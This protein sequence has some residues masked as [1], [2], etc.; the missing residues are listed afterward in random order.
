[1]QGVEARL[2]GDQP[3]DRSRSRLPSLRGSLLDRRGNALAASEDTATIFA[4]PPE[5]SKPALAAEKLAPILG[6][7]ESKVLGA[8]TAETTYSVLA[9]Q[10][11]LPTA[12]RIE[13]LELQGIGQD[14]DSRRIYPQG[15]LAAQVIGA[16]GTEN[17]GLTGLEEGE[18]SVLRG[19]D[20]ER[21]IVTDATG[22]PIRLE[23]AQ[24][25]EDGEDI[26]LTLDPGDRAE[27]RGSAGRSR[28]NL[29]AEGR[30]RDRD[31]PAQLAGPGD[32]QLAAGRSQRPLQRQPRRPA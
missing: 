25:A 30:H 10:V 22:E 1:M 11:D 31:G 14:P 29:R 18:E 27:D 19:T 32:G 15:E 17:E 7:S 8:V 5:V 2:R 6:L 26:Q 3:A 12:K 21:R 4:V 16:V 28:R 13:R 9:K 24:E 20:G 23:T